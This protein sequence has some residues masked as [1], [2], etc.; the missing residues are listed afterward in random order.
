MLAIFGDTPFKPRTP[1]HHSLDNLSWWHQILNAPPHPLPIPGPTPILNFNVFSD[2][3]SGFGIG[4]TL[5]DHWKA[6]KLCPDWK[7]DNCNIGWA[8]S[9]GFELLVLHVISDGTSDLH[10]QVFGDNRGVVEGWWNGHSH[11]GPTN[12]TFKHIH[13]ALKAANCVIHTRYIPSGINPTDGPSQGIYPPI[14]LMLPDLPI[15]HALC[16]FIDNITMAHIPPHPASPTPIQKSLPLHPSCPPTG[17]PNASGLVPLTASN[18]PESLTTQRTRPPFPADLTP[19]PSPLRPSCPARNRLQQWR[20]PNSCPQHGTQVP[21]LSSDDLSRIEHTISHAWADSTKE[22]Y[23]SGLLVYH[24]FCDSKSILEAQRAPASSILIS[25][26]LTNLA[27]LYSSTTVTNYLQG[28]CAWHIMHSLEWAIK[29]D[30]VIPLLKAVATLA[31]PSSKCK[32]REPY[33]VDLIA[34]ICRQLDISTPLHAAVFACLTTTF[35]ATTRVSEFTIPRLDAFDTAKHIKLGDM[36]HEVDR[37]I[38]KPALLCTE[39]QT[40]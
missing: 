3:S 4:I 8:E 35:Y 33:T 2:A 34:S 14:H 11:N 31:P 12:D 20:P 15:P 32:P 21:I 39:S 6:W 1:P 26:F 29:D 24:V 13:S 9:I 7:S 36:R 18:P 19:I 5:G 22:T 17:R 10:F 16:P 40:L 25:L 28:V 30:E 38:S 23:G 37:H 27:G